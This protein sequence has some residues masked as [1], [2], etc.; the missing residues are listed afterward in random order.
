MDDVPC[1][2]KVIPNH[3]RFP[4]SGVESLENG[5]PS[6]TKRGTAKSFRFIVVE[7]G[8]A[9]NNQKFISSV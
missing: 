4:T 2:A 9:T 6:I 3:Y 7:K 1:E 8:K 5:T